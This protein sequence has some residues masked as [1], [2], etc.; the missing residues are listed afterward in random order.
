MTPARI[1]F[2]YSHVVRCTISNATGSGACLEVASPLPDR[3]DLVSD[4][5]VHECQVIC[6]EGDRVEVSFRQG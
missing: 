2:A 1:V 3:F 5:D 4:N 6:R